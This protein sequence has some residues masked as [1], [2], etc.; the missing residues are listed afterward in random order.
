MLLWLGKVQKHTNWYWA[1]NRP[2]ADAL[3]CRESLECAVMWDAKCSSSTS[4]SHRGHFT[5]SR[6][7]VGS[8]WERSISPISCGM[9]KF[10]LYCIL[11][12]K[13]CS[14]EPEMSFASSLS[15]LSWRPSKLSPKLSVQALHLWDDTQNCHEGNYIIFKPA[16]QALRDCV[17]VFWVFIGSSISCAKDVEFKMA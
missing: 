4:F 11:A 17:N 5:L 2:L 7:A 6:A 1:H 3:A 8:I 10:I 16:L 15:F 13:T 12:T 14:L 9:T